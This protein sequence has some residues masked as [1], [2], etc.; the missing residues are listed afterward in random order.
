MTDFPSRAPPARR[1]FSVAA[2]GAAFLLAVAGARADGPPPLIPR[3][4]LFGAPEFSQ[5]TISPDGAWLAW[6]APRDGIPN[7]WVRAIDGAS[8]PRPVT[9]D[10]RRGIHK[11]FWGGDGRILFLQDADGDENWR[12]Y[13]VDLASG[14][15]RD[16]TP[17][18]GVR[19]RV[20]AQSPSS[21]DR[22]IVAMN[23][24]DRRRFDVYDLDLG[25][26]APRRV[27]TND[28]AVTS[29]FADPDLRVL[30][31]AA[32]TDDG[33][34]ELRLRADEASPWTRAAA[35]NADDAANSGVLGFGPGGRTVYL[36]DSRGRDTAALVEMDV[37]TGA[38]R[39]LASD[40]DYDAGEALQHP[41]TQAV[42]AV[43]F[44][45]EK[46]SWRFLD[47]ARAAVFDRLTADGAEVDVT[48]RD[49]RD[50]RWVVRVRRDDAPVATYLLDR[51]TG[52]A[53]FLHWHKPALRR[54]TLARTEPIRLDARDGLTLHGYLTFPA[55]G[56][57]TNLPTVLSVHGGPW[58]R[59]QWGYDPWVQ[60]LAN[61]GYLCLQ[62]NYRGSTG[63][64]K[65]F[66]NAGDREWGA[67]MQDDLTDAV[68]WAV[69]QGHADPSRL[70]IA[71]ASYGGYAALAAA[72]FTPDLF[73]CAVD[74]Y[75]PSN[76]LTLL[77]SLPPYWSA[78]RRIFERRVGHVEDDREMLRARSPLFHADRMRIPILIAQ[79]AN[80]VRVPPAESE[81]IVAALR[82][83]GIAVEYLFFP[84]EGH[85]FIRDENNLRYVAAAERFLARHLGGRCEPEEGGAVPAG[86]ATGG[87]GSAAAP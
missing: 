64:G 73:R 4:I 65:R 45:R 25:G 43:R 85:G 44:V 14:G 22:L 13:G 31:A 37:A 53:E 26:S 10:R 7:I 52:A 15:R 17:F 78:Q 82:A 33:G 69:A 35:W 30:G 74:A 46:A 6:R 71:G 63:Y 77:R 49:R 60:W 32:A 51:E 42:E 2:A 11:Y 81:Q 1:G 18:E 38:V 84:D 24:D 8:P 28:G 80:D 12:L 55:G 5:A 50:R 39:E 3:S 61:R 79:G 68:R 41:E 72:A 86:A 75:G 70:A 76:L 19:V 87:E 67:R 56:A 57:R 27:A 9:D 21:P 40:P 36:A 47:P 34:F 20:V 48:S 59:D 58:A 23:K 16:Y 66:M 29:W 54:Y 62:V 83:R